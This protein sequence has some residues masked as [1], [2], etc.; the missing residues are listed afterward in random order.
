LRFATA[1]PED[2]PPGTKAAVGYSN[3]LVA[4][5]KRTGVV[6]ALYI[7]IAYVHILA[8]VKMKAIVVF[9]YAVVYSNAMQLYLFAMQNAKTMVGAAG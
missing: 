2:R 3:K 6:L 8:V 9:V 7:A 5:K 4:A 1:K